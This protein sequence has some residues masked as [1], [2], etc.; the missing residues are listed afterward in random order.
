[1]FVFY[2]TPARYEDFHDIVKNVSNEVEKKEFPE[3]KCPL[4]PRVIVSIFSVPISSLIDT[5]GQI[6]AMAE[7]FYFY[8][9]NIIK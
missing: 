1:M 8:L 4:C 9:K 3:S 6:T 7:P 5:G 2:V